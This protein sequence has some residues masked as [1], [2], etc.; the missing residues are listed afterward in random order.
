MFAAWYCVLIATS[1]ACSSPSQEDAPKQPPAETCP[2]VGAALQ[3]VS[4]HERRLRRAWL[5]QHPGATDASSEV[6]VDVL[7]IGSLHLVGDVLRHLN[8]EV[9]A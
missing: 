9:R 5:E 7:V 8:I 3:L 1:R 4:D 6:G 2:S